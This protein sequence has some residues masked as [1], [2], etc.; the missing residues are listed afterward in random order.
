MTAT[1]TLGELS[2]TKTYDFTVLAKEEDYAYL[3][4][5]FTGNN[6]DQERLFYGV[7]LDGYNFRA[8]N[9]GRSVLTS[10]LGTGCIR[11]PFIMKGED[12]YY[13]IIATDMRSSLG[14]SSNYATVVYKTPDLINIVDKEW[15]N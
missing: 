4:A 10:D 3:F 2:V 13:Y 6:A 14:W 11:D 7:S 15:I 12:G 8:L 9:G 1:F 5:Y